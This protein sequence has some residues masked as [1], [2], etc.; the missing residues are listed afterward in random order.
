MTQVIFLIVFISAEKRKFTQ[1]L[2]VGTNLPTTE[3]AYK[4]MTKY[5]LLCLSRPWMQTVNIA[6]E[7][8]YNAW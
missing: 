8:K 7:S 6:V 4:G 5:L 3:D 2:N 1:M